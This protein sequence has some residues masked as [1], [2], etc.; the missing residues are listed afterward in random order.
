MTSL[1]VPAFVLGLTGLIALVE[2]SID[3]WQSLATS[4]EFGSNMVAITSK[5]SMEYYRFL[6]WAR[7]SGIFHAG[8]MSPETH[9]PPKIDE[10]HQS[11]VGPDMASTLR[12]P[13]EEAVAQV[14]T[15]L[16]EVF[17]I[18]SE[19]ALDAPA[20]GYNGNRSTDSRGTPS[21]AMGLST[22]LPLFGAPCNPGVVATL[23]KQK[24][25]ANELRDQTPFNIRFRFST[26]PWNTANKAALEEKINRL[27]YWNDR[28]EGLL[29]NAIKVSLERQGLAAHLLSDKNTKI[30]EALIEASN[31]G[32]EGVRTHAKLW[33]ERIDLERLESAKGFYTHQYRRNLSVILNLSDLQPSKCRLSL[34]LFQESK[35]QCKRFITNFTPHTDIGKLL[36]R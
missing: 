20:Q 18:T 5:L 28:L 34:K 19:Y 27:C 32:N 22:T 6:A 15:L 3:I 12:A 36:P 29:P 30:L 23:L 2:K 1:E 14:V 35:T 4:K 7:V 8:P 17:K 26:S 9:I 11:R 13:I 31:H 16:E 33:K 10:S 24:N 25:Q 21:I